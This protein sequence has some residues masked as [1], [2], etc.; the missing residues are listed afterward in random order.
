MAEV[1]FDAGIQEP[2]VYGGN[3]LAA[4]PGRWWHLLSQKDKS[5]LFQNQVEATLK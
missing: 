4:Q 5:C 1:A 3:H 2:W